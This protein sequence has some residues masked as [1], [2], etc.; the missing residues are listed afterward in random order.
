MKRSP[1]FIFAL[2]LVAL[3]FAP[4][5]VGTSTPSQTQ[6]FNIDSVLV[7]VVVMN[8]GRINVTYWMTFSVSSGSL[9]GFDLFGIQE[10][11]IYDTGRAYVVMGENRYDLTVEVVSEGY[12]LDWL[13]R[14]QEG[15]TVTVVFGYFSTNRI[16]EKTTGTYTLEGSDEEVTGDL[17][18]LNWAPVIWGYSVGFENVRVIYPIAMNASWITGEGGIT[19]DGADY[20]GYVVDYRQGLYDVSETQYSFD[21]E[22]LLAYPSDSGASPRYFSVSLNHSSLSALDHFRVFHY[23]NWSWYEPYLLPGILA[24]E[25]TGIINAYADTEFSVAATLYNFG[26]ADLENVT[27]SMNY[28]ANLTLTSERTSWYVDSMSGGDALYILCTFVPENLPAI[29]TITFLVSADNVD[30]GGWLVIEIPVYVAEVVPPLIDPQMLA[31]GVGSLFAI[32]L[33]A[34]GY[35]KVTSSYGARWNADETTTGYLSPE[36]AIQTFGTPGM[37]A[38]LD[39]VESALFV[40]T[41]RKKMIS[42]ILMS[43]VRKG[44]VR[45]ISSD[46]L[47]LSVTGLQFV[48]LTYYEELFLDAIVSN[49]LDTDKVDDMI[50]EI[51]DKVQAK[52]WDADFEATKAANDERVEGA[53]EK[54]ESNPTLEGRTDYYF[55]EDYDDNGW[56]W[57]YL[58]QHPRHDAYLEDAFRHPG[59]TISPPEIPAWFND[60]SE[61]TG[62]AISDVGRVVGDV[63]ATTSEIM[64]NVA[65]T[66]G[67]VFEG[68]GLSLIHI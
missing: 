13:P 32:G 21:E 31:F 37:V 49:E 24:F 54:L 30:P 42:M 68:V 47:N 65:N 23:T 40:N 41:S 3:A 35:K 29:L 46:P 1:R 66:I 53:W 25:T 5:C 18:V 20:A 56:A 10:T 55:D 38:D 59:G 58:Y 11:S 43:C 52:A 62:H 34:Y 4:M 36:I 8:N 61:A 6:V 51:A 57:F 39:P 33:I 64:S 15:E 26:D 16:L 44:A 48:E 17:A 45:V 2:M 22:N 14:T 67:D 27:V 63:A 60:L 7:D 19:P 50:E 9:G 28:H 12:K